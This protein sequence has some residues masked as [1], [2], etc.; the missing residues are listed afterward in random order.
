MLP[1]LCVIYKSVLSDKPIYEQCNTITA[2]KQQETKLL[3]WPVA[4][5]VAKII[6]SAD[7]TQI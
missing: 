6:F 2:F 3:E 1:H 5:A 7:N 4:V